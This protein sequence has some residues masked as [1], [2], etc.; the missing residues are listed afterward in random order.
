MHVKTLKGHSLGV[1][2][3]VLSGHYLYSGSDD[4]TIR[5]TLPV[6]LEAPRAM[7][8]WQAYIYI[9]IYMGNTHTI[10]L[11]ARCV[12]VR[13]YVCGSENRE[14]RVEHCADGRNGFI[15]IYN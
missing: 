8:R 6:S 9:Y 2:S 12:P 14:Q 7:P 5:V 15:A 13:V 1:N 4:R 11:T 3:L 10:S